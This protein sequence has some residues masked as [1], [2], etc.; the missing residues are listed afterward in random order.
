MNI[1]KIIKLLEL[2][3]DIHD[4]LA[5]YFGDFKS[6]MDT[7][8]LEIRRN[9]GGLN[10]Y[11]PKLNRDVPTF[12]TI[13]NR[14]LSIFEE[15]P[16]SIQ[17][18]TGLYILSNHVSNG[19]MLNN[20]DSLVPYDDNFESTFFQKSTLYD[21][22]FSSD[23]VI[24][25]FEFLKSLRGSFEVWLSPHEDFFNASDID[26]DAI[27]IDLTQYRETYAKRV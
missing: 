2:A 4:G 5:L 26:L 27:I 16:S 3:H 13:A 12:R 20:A 10:I 9:G 15:L 21:Y 7:K 18:M 1:E 19:I 24:K 8:N 25:I 23:E 11:F 22:P 6:S 14:T 17:C